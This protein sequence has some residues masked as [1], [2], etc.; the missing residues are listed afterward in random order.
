[1]PNG[2]TAEVGD[3]CFGCESELMFAAQTSQTRDEIDNAL[4]T[5]PAISAIK[6]I[7]ELTGCGLRVAI[8]IRNDRWQGAEEW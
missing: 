2:P 1:M 7:R 5:L 3:P 8:G 4:A 6:R